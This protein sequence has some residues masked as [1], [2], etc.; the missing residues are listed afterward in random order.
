MVRLNARAFFSLLGRLVLAAV[1][2][3]AALPKIQDPVAFAASIE[4]FHII[5]GSGAM[6]AA[7]ALPWLELVIALGLL[8]PWLRRASAYSMALLLGLFIALHASAWARGLN[9]N[10]GCFGESASNPDYHWLILRNLALL[11]LTIYILRIA[12]RNNNLANKS[13]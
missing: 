1:F 13:N 5:T 10:C 7:T 2:I 3:L 6:A 11:L 9:I 12:L 8:T 4:G